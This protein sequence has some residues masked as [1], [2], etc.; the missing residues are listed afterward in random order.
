MCRATLLVVETYCL[1]GATLTEGM[2]AAE[3]CYI[4][5]QNIKKWLINLFHS[6]SRKLEVSLNVHRNI[7]CVLTTISSN[8]NCFYPNTPGPSSSLAVYDQ[9]LLLCS[10]DR[11]RKAESG[12]G[13]LQ[14]NLL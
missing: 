7:H 13:V 6:F 3:G 10:T 1:G 11:G 9:R 4:R 12:A 2:F 8:V 5:S 14:R